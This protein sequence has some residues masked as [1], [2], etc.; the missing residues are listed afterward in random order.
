MSKDIV[1]ANVLN[2]RLKFRGPAFPLPTVF[3][4]VMVTSGQPHD[5]LK[6]EGEDTLE[7]ERFLGTLFPVRSLE[8]QVQ[9]QVFRS[10]EPAMYPRLLVVLKPAYLSSSPPFPSASCLGT[11]ALLTL[12]LS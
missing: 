9:G 7:P 10:Q 3:L 6:G 8:N 11:L 12:L 1:F 5:M 4:D 2:S